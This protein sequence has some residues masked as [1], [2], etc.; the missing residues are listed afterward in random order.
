VA[1]KLSDLTLDS[2]AAAELLEKMALI[3]GIISDWQA[4][5]R[6]NK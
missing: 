5:Q 2:E 1:F 6:E 4:Q 3:A